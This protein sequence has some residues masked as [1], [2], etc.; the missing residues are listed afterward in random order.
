MLLIMRSCSVFDFCG[1]MQACVNT[2]RPNWAPLKRTVNEAS[3]T[4]GE[5]TQVKRAWAAT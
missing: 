2:T 3:G 1:S 5:Q 4:Q